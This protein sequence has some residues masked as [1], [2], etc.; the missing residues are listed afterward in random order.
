MRH[1]QIDDLKWYPCIPYNFILTNEI[2]EGLFTKLSYRN[3]ML[4][5]VFEE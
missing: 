5:D 4:L 1:N 2:Q 3:K